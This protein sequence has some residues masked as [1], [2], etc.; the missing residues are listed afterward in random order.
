MQSL[1]KAITVPK[2]DPLV[3]L[4]RL[5]KGIFMQLAK[6]TEMPPQEENWEKLPKYKVA[7]AVARV[8][9]RIID[10]EPSTWMPNASKLNDTVEETYQVAIAADNAQ[11]RD[12]TSLAYAYLS[13]RIKGSDALLKEFKT[14]GFSG[15]QSTETG[16]QLLHNAGLGNILPHPTESNPYPADWVKKVLK[17]PLVPADKEILPNPEGISSNEGSPAISIYDPEHKFA[18]DR[19]RKASKPKGRGKGAG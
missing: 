1:L 7:L 17:K 14:I 13:R 8:A 2:K 5:E 18:S 19:N 6:I 4:S 11:V 15:K 9:S 3:E 16:E 12:I 10:N